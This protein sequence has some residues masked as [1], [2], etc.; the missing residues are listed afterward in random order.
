MDLL[1][2]GVTMREWYVRM[3]AISLGIRAS[4]FR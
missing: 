3:S 1:L 4:E 2:E